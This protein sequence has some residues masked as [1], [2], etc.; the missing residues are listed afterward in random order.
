MQSKGYSQWY[1]HLRRVLVAEHGVLIVI[2]FSVNFH[3]FKLISFL[4]QEQGFWWVVLF[5]VLDLLLSWFVDVISVCF[6]FL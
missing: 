2:M 5:F 1:E 6:C 3:S 4:G